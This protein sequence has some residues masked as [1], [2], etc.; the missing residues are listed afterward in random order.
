MR[1]LIVLTLAFAT[2]VAAG[3]EHFRKVSNR[4]WLLP[5]TAQLGEGRDDWACTLDRRSGLTWEVKT[6]SGMRSATYKYTWLRGTLGNV[7]STST[8]GNSLGGMQCNTQN[9]AANVNDATLCGASDWRVSG[10]SYSSGYA[11]GNP[12]G[13]LAVLYQHLFA[14]S[15]INPDDW[16]PNLQPFWYWT[17]VTYPLE[18]ATSWLVNFGTAKAFYNYWDLPYHVVLVSDTAGDVFFADGFD[19][20]TDFDE[21]FDSLDEV[22]A[23]GWLVGNLSE[24]EGEFGWFYG[25]DNV[26]PAQ[27]G[28][29]TS[30]V[31]ANYAAV[32]D[33]G[34]ISAWLLTPL[35][36]FRAGS[37]LSFWTRTVTGAPRAERLQVL[38]CV[39]GPC[40]YIGPGALG[41]SDFGTLLLDLNPNL[42]TGNDSTGVYGYP[43]HWVQFTLDANQGMPTEGSGRIAFRYFVEDGGLNGANSNYIGLDS[44]HI[45]ATAVE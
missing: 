4:G 45:S 13:E 8:C 6:T 36:N 15:G 19:A 23:R 43:D 16:M 9:Y 7:G 3:G 31:H 35:L 29:S 17:D 41:Y 11:S 44:V 18:Y 40:D 28:A 12:N 32:A 27:A 33:S 5:D 38:A 30:Q 10:G 22:N 24:P 25:G 34:T 39:G 21:G 37:T 14:A 1:S 26:F 20:A 42:L 2:G